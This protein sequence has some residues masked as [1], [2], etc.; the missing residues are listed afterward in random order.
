MPPSFITAAL[1]GHSRRRRVLVFSSATGSPVVQDGRGSAGALVG[2]ELLQPADLALAGVEAVALQFQGVRVEAFG[3]PA[4]HVAQ[5]FAPLLDLAAATLEDPQ[6][7]RLV[8]P[9]EEREV[10]AEAGVVVRLGAGLG[11]QLREPFLAL[12]GDLVDDPTAP[13]GQRRDLVRGDRRRLGLGDP[14]GR[15]QPAQGRVERAV[16][17]RRAD[18]AE[19]GGRAPCAA[20][21]RAWAIPAGVRGWRVRAPC[22]PPPGPLRTFVRC[23]GP[24]HRTVDRSPRIRQTHRSAAATTTQSDRCRLV[25]ARPRTLFPMRTQRQVVDY[26]LQKRAVLRERALRPGRHATRSVT[27]RRT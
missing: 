11:E 25:R 24:I 5:A 15:L 1:P 18:R 14:A 12:G 19:L 6:A 8:G 17:D 20:R 4:E 7:G 21:S 23:I 13:A 9:G 27:P 22:R 26:S 16:A 3:G 10:H 2:D